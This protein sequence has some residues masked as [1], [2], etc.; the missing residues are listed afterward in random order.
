M[1]QSWEGDR[2]L[3][4]HGQDYSTRTIWCSTDA[5]SNGKW[6]TS[7]RD[8]QVDV[9]PVT[10]AQDD[11]EISLTTRSKDHNGHRGADSMSRK[12]RTMELHFAGRSVGP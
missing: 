12:M 3:G 5:T 11:M 2:E 8:W 4:G 1:L 10:L 6:E 9:A 7:V